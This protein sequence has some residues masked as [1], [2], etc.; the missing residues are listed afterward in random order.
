MPH[1]GPPQALEQN[2][3]RSPQA[4]VAASLFLLS[5][6][7]DWT[8]DKLKRFL[9][10][11]IM[12]NLYY[13]IEFALDEAVQ[14]VILVQGCVTSADGQNKYFGPCYLPQ[15][16]RQMKLP[17]S[18]TTRPRPVML[19]TTLMRYHLPAELDWYHQPLRP[20]DYVPRAA[21]DEEYAHW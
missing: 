6:I 13:A 21:T 15:S 18:P 4:Y 5:A 16:L 19:I 11:G 20:H 3:C 10:G 2:T 17:D 14:D 1:H 7:Q 9:E 12:P 8:H